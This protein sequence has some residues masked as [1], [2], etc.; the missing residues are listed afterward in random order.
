MQQIFKNAMIV[1]A[2]EVLHGYVVVADG[3]IIEVGSGKSP[4]G[5]QDCACDLLIPGVLSTEPSAIA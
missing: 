3:K 4:D 5:G 2:D 1:T